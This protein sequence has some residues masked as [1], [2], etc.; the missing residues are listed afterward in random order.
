M[1]ITDLT[2]NIS[3]Q[4]TDNSFS[5]YQTYGHVSV[6]YRVLD[7][8]FEVNTLGGRYVGAARS[9][10]IVAQMVYDALYKVSA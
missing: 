9:V 1:N 6:F 10:K 5:T 4:R 3:R 7:D 8:I 2:A